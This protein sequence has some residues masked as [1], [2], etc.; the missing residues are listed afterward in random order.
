MAYVLPTEDEDEKARQESAGSAGPAA[1]AAPAIS[2]GGAP[3]HPMGGAGASGR[4]AKPSTNFV[5]FDRLLGANKDAATAYSK[6]VAQPL[7]QA[8][9]AS[10]Q[11]VASASN[12]FANKVQA[13]LP[14]QMQPAAPFS[15]KPAA[16]QQPTGKPTSPYAALSAQTVPGFASPT[17]SKPASPTNTA[18]QS[19]GPVSGATLTPEQARAQSEW[20][21][22]GPNS[23][24][25]DA[26][27]GDILA[28]A[29]E[30]Q[31]DVGLTGHRN[32]AGEL[33]GDA[34]IQALLQSQVGGPYTQGQSKMDAGLLGSAG[35]PE[36]DRLNEEYGNLVGG[37]KAANEASK[38]VSDAARANVKTQADAARSAL[39]RQAAANAATEAANAAA[40]K[41]SQERLD[42]MHLKS[43]EGKAEDWKAYTENNRFENTVGDIG[44]ALDPVS[45]AVTGATGKSHHGAAREAMDKGINSMGGKLNS[46]KFNWG[47]TGPL[48]GL[49]DS[50]KMGIYNSLSAE[51]LHNLERMSS[52]DM[53]KF[54]TGRIG[55][56]GKKA[57][58]TLTGPDF[59]GKSDPEVFNLL[60]TQYGFDPQEATSLFHLRDQA[61]RFGLIAPPT[62]AP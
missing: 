41:A 11:A 40:A 39:D 30:A 13:G 58:Q 4:P 43:G 19:Q 16:T 52:N 36:W 50:I 12:A 3:T 35:R 27:W 49:N 15:A 37:A 28:G 34:G 29:G 31:R 55:E 23:M 10:K 57:Q 7:Q 38:G 14:S 61:L 2:G 5:S 17:Q 53:M 32:E 48:S 22:A 47:F 9:Q 60:V 8:G 51:E 45:W 56:L 54:V 1:S 25:E 26:G 59:A 33:R 20:T 18:I 44:E 24:D 6:K 21:Y 46:N 62:S 42:A